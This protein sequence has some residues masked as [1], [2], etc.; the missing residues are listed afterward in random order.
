[1]TAWLSVIGIG[2]DG[3]AG[4]SPAARTLIDTADVLIGGERHL[5]MIPANGAERQR[6]SS[7]LVA[8]ADRIPAMRGRRVVVL[9][10]G[11]PMLFGIGATLSRVVP[12][13]EMTV[14]PA[15]SA[16]ALA[17]A[18]LAWPLEGVAAINLQGRPVE[19]LALHVSPGAR[20]LLLSHDQ[21]SPPAVA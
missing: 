4:L 5:A 9:A 19:Q 3:M 20:L 8:L 14:L 1:M 16:F 17:A 6:W 11:D 21:R 10:T 2:E 13:E 12:A 7:P 18:R 15:V